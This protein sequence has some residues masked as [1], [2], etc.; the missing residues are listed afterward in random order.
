MIH[1]SNG[2][3]ERVIG[4]HLKRIHGGGDDNYGGGDCSSSSCFSCVVDQVIIAHSQKEVQ[5]ALLAV[6]GGKETENEKEGEEEEEEEEEEVDCIVSDLV[7]IEGL[8]EKNYFKGGGGGRRRRRRRR[9]VSRFEE[10]TKGSGGGRR[11]QMGGMVVLLAAPSEQM[12]WEKSEK[13]KKT[14][15]EK[16]EGEQM[17][18]W[19]VNFVRTPLRQLSLVHELTTIFNSYLTTSDD[20]Y[21][22][23]NKQRRRLHEGDDSLQEVVTT[24]SDQQS[25]ESE[26]KV[27]KRN[28]RS[29]AGMEKK[30][31]GP[32]VLVVEDNFVNQ[33]VCKLE[34]HSF[35]H[36]QFFLQLN[37]S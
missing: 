3:N 15:A 10:E 27:E 6:H 35:N 37:Q 28:T 11:R 36:S 18:C 9:S 26:D 22:A 34:F 19:S 14:L 20:S 29:E 8:M 4:S 7:A 17:S 21:D 30:C 33:K 16:E 23:E 31:D 2:T 1:L 13:A 24:R 12:E 5:E 32:L 25:R